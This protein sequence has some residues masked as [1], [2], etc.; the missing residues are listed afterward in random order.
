MQNTKKDVKVHSDGAE[1]EFR[2]NLNIQFDPIASAPLTEDDPIEVLYVPM[3][4]SI[5]FS[6]SLFPTFS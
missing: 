5:R 1:I 4:V 2:I 6:I 3:N